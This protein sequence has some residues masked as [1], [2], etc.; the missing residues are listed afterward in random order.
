MFQMK[1]G[2]R[3]ELLAIEIRDLVLSGAVVKGKRVLNGLIESGH[4][5]GSKPPRS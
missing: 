4:L 1:I 5:V 2:K 3:Q